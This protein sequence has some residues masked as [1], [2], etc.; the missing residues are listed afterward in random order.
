V[1]AWN[2]ER[3][4]AYN[5]TILMVAIKGYDIKMANRILELGANP[6]TTDGNNTPL[7]QAVKYMEVEV[8]LALIKA[9]AKLS[10]CN[11]DNDTAFTISQRESKKTIHKHASDPFQIMTRILSVAKGQES[12]EHRHG[13]QPSSSLYKLWVARG[14]HADQSSSGTGSDGIRSEIQHH[15]SLRLDHQ[16]RPPDMYK[17]LCGETFGETDS[18]SVHVEQSHG[19]LLS[20]GEILKLAVRRRVQ[21]INKDIETE[22]DSDGDFVT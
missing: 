2:L 19:L 8:V 12:P 3:V 7:I 11:F 16:V 13:L 1:Q 18:L 20:H 22:S 5:N 17:C 14:G 6:N 4:D 10:V 15:E 21:R 9:N